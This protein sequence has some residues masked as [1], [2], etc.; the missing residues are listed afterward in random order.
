MSDYICHTNDG[1]NDIMFMFCTIMGGPVEALGGNHLEEQQECR[2]SILP[3]RPHFHQ[4]QYLPRAKGGGLTAIFLTHKF[5][6]GHYLR[7]SLIP[8]Y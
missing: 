4:G 1:Q 2:H 5:Y 6:Q 8:Q 7:C 3:I